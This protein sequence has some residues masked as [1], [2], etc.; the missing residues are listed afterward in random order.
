MGWYFLVGIGGFLLGSILMAILAV[1]G[2]KGE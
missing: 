2:T 1:S